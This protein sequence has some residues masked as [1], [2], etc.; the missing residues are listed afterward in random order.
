MKIFSKEF[1]NLYISIVLEIS[2]QGVNFGTPDE[3]SNFLETPEWPVWSGL[4]GIF[5]KIIFI[6]SPIEW[7]PYF[8]VLINWEELKERMN[9]LLCGMA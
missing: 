9:P 7:I 5:Y 3:D 8:S 4:F 2:L 1:I 6:K